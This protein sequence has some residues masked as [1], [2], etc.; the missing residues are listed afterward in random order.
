MSGSRPARA[1]P[2]HRIWW[3]L[4]GAAVIG[5]VIA[6]VAVSTGWGAPTTPASAS[7]T[8]TAST[9]GPSA[10]ATA[11]ASASPSPSPSK[12]PSA[13]PSAT[14]T[15]SASRTVDRVPYCQAFAQIRTKPVSAESEE[16]GVDFDALADRFADL[17][18]VYGRAAKAAPSSLDR[19]YAVVL[20]Y[21]KDMRTAV[22]TRDLEGIKQMIQNLELLNESMAA[23][24][25]ASEQ[26][27]R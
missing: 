17:I 11:T 22:V 1:L 2:T 19:Q 26:I 9:V 27:C 12:T 20:A 24:Q 8:P 13:T 4:G 14:P 23:I 21:L 15:P 5:L 7:P 3:W 6:I 18:K 10:T 16:G 25:K